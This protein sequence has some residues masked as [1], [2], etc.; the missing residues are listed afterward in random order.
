MIAAYTYAECR[1]LKGYADFV[2]YD[3]YVD[4]NDGRICSASVWMI[5]GTWN[6]E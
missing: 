1:S 3:Y 4:L 5:P 6:G 2:V